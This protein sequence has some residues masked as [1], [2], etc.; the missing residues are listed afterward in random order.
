MDDK[1]KNC[2]S[3]TIPM[4]WR[5]STNHHNDCY[6]CLV[7]VQ[8]HNRKSKKQI[9]C[10]S[11]PSAIMPVPHVKDLPVPLP[12]AVLENIAED[13]EGDEI[14]SEDDVEGDDVYRPED[15]FTPQRF[16]QTELNDLVRDLNLPKE[17]TE[18]LGSGLKVNIFWHQEH[19]FHGT[20]TETN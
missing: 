14:S 18:L 6:F 11:I 10:P 1:E 8:G 4:M 5:E 9:M 15:D 20:D 19:I 16:S 7:N 17:S 2:M 12:P 3:F 13:V